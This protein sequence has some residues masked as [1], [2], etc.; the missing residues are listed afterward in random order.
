MTIIIRWHFVEKYCTKPE[1]EMLLLCMITFKI[2]YIHDYKSSP[3]ILSKKYRLPF[4]AI[5]QDFV[6]I[7]QIASAVGIPFLQGRIGNFRVDQPL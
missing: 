6:I 2:V 5:L 4:A 7:S 1:L 3:V